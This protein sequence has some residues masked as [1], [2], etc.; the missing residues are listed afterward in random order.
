[1]STFLVLRIYIYGRHTHEGRE[2]TAYIYASRSKRVKYVSYATIS[3]IHI[4]VEVK[5]FSEL[6]QFCIMS[7][8]LP[9]K[10]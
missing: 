3:L 2:F 1:M 5:C 4:L 6:E 8:S 10:L 9:L 7:Q